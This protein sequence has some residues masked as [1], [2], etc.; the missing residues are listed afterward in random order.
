MST[1]R[2][3]YLH[4]G[5]YKS[6]DPKKPDILEIQII[7]EETFPTAFSESCHV[8]HL[9]NNQWNEK[10]LPLQNYDSDNTELMQAWSRAEKQGKIK[11]GNIIKIVTWLGKSKKNP[12]RNMRRFRIR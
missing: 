11:P 7:T 10:I 4:W 5:D 3:P 8:K 1:Q 6:H 9:Q 12:E 2:I